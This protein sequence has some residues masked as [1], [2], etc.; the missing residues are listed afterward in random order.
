MRPLTAEEKKEM[1]HRRAVAYR[2]MAA[3]LAKQGHADVAVRV[4]A[5]A[6][7]PDLDTDELFTAALLP[8]DTPREVVQSI[9]LA[10]KI[11]TIADNLGQDAHGKR[12]IIALIRACA[13]LGAIYE[14][15][16]K[17]YV[18]TDDDRPVD[19]GMIETWRKE[20]RD[21]GVIFDDMIGKIDG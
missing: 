7:S 6:M 5:L 12:P 15:V 13:A 20:G 19:D 9:V 18:V 11:R 14:G 1:L 3:N 10:A 4:R 17:K 2:E 8:D 21:A 16:A